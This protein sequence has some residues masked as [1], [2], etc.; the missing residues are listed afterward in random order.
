[1][2]WGQ[3]NRKILKT[4]SKKSEKHYKKTFFQIKN[5]F[6]INLKYVEFVYDFTFFKK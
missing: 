4:V 5:V 6:I 1:M 2:K 3:K